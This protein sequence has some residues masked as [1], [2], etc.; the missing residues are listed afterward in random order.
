MKKL[1]NIALMACCLL[2]T[3]CDMDIV[4][5][6]QST[7]Q[8]TT[9]LELMLNSKTISGRPHETLGLV[10]NEGYGSGFTTIKKQ[11]EAENTVTAIYL[12]YNENADRG[13]LATKDN[14]YSNIYSNVYY[15]NVIID[16]IDDADGDNNRKAAIKAEAMVT[17]GYNIFLAAN[18]YAR[19]YD[20][21]T[22][23]EAGGVAYP[24]GTDVDTKPQLKLQECYDRILADCSDENIAQLPDRGNV[25]RIN[26]AGGNAIRAAV[27]FQMKRY[28]EALTYADKA[29]ALN[30][31]IEDRSYIVDT[32]NWKLLP[33][34]ENNFFYIS[35]LSDM[36]KNPQYER[37][38]WETA[39]LFEEGDYV[40][41]YS[42][43]GGYSPYWDDYYGYLDSGIDGCLEAYGDVYTNPWGLTVEQIMYLAAECHIRKGEIQK[44]LD[45]INKVRSYRIHPDS[46]ISFT[47][48]SETDAMGLL[49]R[50]KFVECIGSFWNFF[51]RKRWNTE[52]KYRK[53]ITRDLQ[54]AGKYSIAP[55]SKLWIFPFPLRVI[56]NNSTFKQNYE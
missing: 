47:A 30:S 23:A 28:D 51:D 10:V 31:T 39:E 1:S 9:D 21:A 43:D 8:R 5:K 7:L 26:K 33:S 2:A 49:Q 22:A 56:Q 24:E 52:D 3:S 6:G 17:R 29:L 27:L 38:S 25:S 50:A 4:P 53:T 40:K 54:D 14:T 45:M 32:E 11:I 35:P 12:T 20:A 15:M 18:I 41:D 13:A 42:T 34:S 19:Q 16:K 46:F 37:L 55:D 48:S 44:G 36:T